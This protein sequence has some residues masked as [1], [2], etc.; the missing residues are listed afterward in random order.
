MKSRKVVS[1]TI[2]W[3]SVWALG[4]AT[5][6]AVSV[7]AQAQ[8]AP[9]AEARLKELKIVL[10]PVANYVDAVRATEAWTRGGKPPRKGAV[11][12][13]KKVRSHVMRNAGP[14][15]QS[16]GSPIPVFPQNEL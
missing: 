5:W 16:S 8:N 15:A 14:L 11:S 13:W 1:L 2:S 9:S 7:C 6:I 10:P 4:L 3:V 12:S